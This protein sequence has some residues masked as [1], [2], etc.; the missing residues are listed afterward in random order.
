MND[1]A[2]QAAQPEREAR[3]EIKQRANN[4]DEAAKHQQGP[5]KFAEWVHGASLKLLR[6]EV[7]GGPPIV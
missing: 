5:S 6:F 4:D 2:G 1:I 3:T 7:K